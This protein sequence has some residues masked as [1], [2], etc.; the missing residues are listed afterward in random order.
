MNAA[1]FAGRTLPFI[2]L[3]GKLLQRFKLNQLCFKVIVAYKLTK[4]YVLL[5]H[6]FNLFIY[7]RF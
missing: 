3:P 5:G 2:P 1:F 6:L 7:V 4:A